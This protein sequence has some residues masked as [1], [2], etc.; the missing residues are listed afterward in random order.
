MLIA[1]ETV[2]L[3]GPARLAEARGEVAVHEELRT[4]PDHVERPELRA[5]EAQA[6]K[7][8]H[9]EKRL[10][11]EEH[12]PLVLEHIHRGRDEWK[13]DE[14]EVDDEPAAQTQTHTSTPCFLSRR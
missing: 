13:M 1:A 12:Q 9:D 3:I 11:Q 7:E 4:G 5:N 8:R 10:D 6:G 14:R 2:S